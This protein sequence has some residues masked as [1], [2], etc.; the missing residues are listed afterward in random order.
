M[1]FNST[2]QTKNFSLS[3]FELQKAKLDNTQIVV[4]GISSG[5]SLYL[6][7]CTLLYTIVKRKDK[8]VFDNCCCL[9]TTLSTVFAISTIL[10]KIVFWRYYLSTCRVLNTLLFTILVL[11]RCSIHLVFRSRYNSMYR[12]KNKQKK[13]LVYTKFF[14][15]LSMLQLLVNYLTAFWLGNPKLCISGKPIKISLYLLSFVFFFNVYRTNN[16]KY[17]D[18]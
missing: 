15:I 1:G 18:H 6:F 14:I 9:F 17:C 10:C 8:L 5:F 11:S 12:C 7:F 16:N 3:L 13:V 4:F 2:M